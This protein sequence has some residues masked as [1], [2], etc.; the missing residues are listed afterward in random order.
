MCQSSPCCCQSNLPDTH[1]ARFP[2]TFLLKPK[3]KTW[4]LMSLCTKTNP[5]RPNRSTSQTWQLCSSLHQLSFSRPDCLTSPLTPPLIAPRLSSR[6]L[7]TS[8]VSRCHALHHPNLLYLPPSRLPL[9]CEADET[10]SPG[11]NAPPVLAFL[12]TCL[13]TALSP[14]Q[15]EAKNLNSFHLQGCFCSCLH[16]WASIWHF[17]SAKFQ[18]FM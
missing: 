9:L 4:E 5:R 16:T 7:T 14:S 8:S 2:C 13:Q 3:T 1:G 10:R 6:R 15:G 17:L 12:F 18:T 11:N